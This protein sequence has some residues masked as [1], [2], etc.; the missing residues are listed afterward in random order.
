[1]KTNVGNL[2]RLNNRNSGLIVLTQVHKDGIEFM[3]I[4]S[5]L[6][7][8]TSRR[9]MLAWYRAGDLTPVVVKK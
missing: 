6:K 3:W 8:R 7:G 4:D 5:G 2:F 9:I 1:M